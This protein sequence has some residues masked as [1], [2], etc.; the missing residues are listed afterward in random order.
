MV[1]GNIPSLINTVV[2]AAL[3]LLNCSE[4]QAFLFLREQRKAVRDLLGWIGAKIDAAE[5]AGAPVPLLESLKSRFADRGPAGRRRCIVAEYSMM[6]VAGIETTAAALTFAIAE[7]ANN[8]SVRDEVI[9]E[10]RREAEAEFDGE[11]LTLQYPY[12]YHVLRETLRRHTIVP[13]M[14]REAESDQEII[15]NRTGNC[16]GETVEIG[17]TVDIKR[18]SVLRYLPVQGN[19]RRS[20]WEHPH[21]FDPDRFGRPLTAEQKKSH[22]TFGIGPQSCPGRAMAITENILILKAFFERFDLEH[23]PITQNIS[24]ERNVLLT[25]RPVGVTARVRAAAGRAEQHSQV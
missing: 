10:A 7:I 1:R 20:I 19:M 14:L 23:K 15:G 9:T 16:S 3:H 18:G 21:R 12:V 24:V 11:A 13:T 4:H 22:H 17:E 25:I 8:V 6:F 2:A 5:L